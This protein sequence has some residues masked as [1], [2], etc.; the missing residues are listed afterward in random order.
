MHG[1]AREADADLSIGE[2][3]APLGKI[4]ARYIIAL[5]VLLAVSAFFANAGS[6]GAASAVAPLAAGAPALYPWLLADT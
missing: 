5:A 4:N 2:L 3:P 1:V 6:A